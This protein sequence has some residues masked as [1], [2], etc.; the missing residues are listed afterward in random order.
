MLGRKVR[1][2]NDQQKFTYAYADFHYESILFIVVQNNGFYSIN[3]YF[4]MVKRIYPAITPVYRNKYKLL[5][6]LCNERFNHIRVVFYNYSIIFSPCK[7]KE[8]GKVN[9]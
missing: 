3:Q 2:G 6:V 5:Y 4:E 8:K 7:R 9:V 1:Q